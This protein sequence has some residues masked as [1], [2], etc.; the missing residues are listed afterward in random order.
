MKAVRLHRHGGPDVLVHEEVATPEPGPGQ[1]LI[2]VEAVAVNYADTMRRRNDPYTF[3]SEPPFIPGG[4][5]AGTIEA[6]GP[7]VEGPPVGTAVFATVGAGGSTGYAQFAV[8]NAG[9]VIPIP[10]GLD[11]AQASALVVAGVTAVLTIRDAGRLQKGES[12]LVQAAAGGVGSYAVQLAKLL[13]A[14]TVIAAASTAEKRAAALALGADHAVDYSAPGWTDQVRELTGGKGVDLVLEMTGGP[15]FAESLS[16]L[17]PFGRSVVYGLAS[18]AFAPFDPQTTIVGM[19]QSVIG[20]YLGGY[21]VHRSA[22]AIGALQLLIG[23]VLSGAVKVQ[24][25]HVLPLSRAAEAHR[26]LESRETTGKI[27]LQPWAP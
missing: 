5:V 14:G 4:E 9:Q 3:P 21:F 7:G 1:L 6:L 15:I 19:N 10:P 24:I 23:H 25:G 26:L 22:E 8:A 20:F 16:A 17:A 27:I 2:R 11:A 13:G 12:V 18:R